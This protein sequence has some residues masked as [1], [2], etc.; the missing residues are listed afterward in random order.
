MTIKRRKFLKNSLLGALLGGTSCTAFSQP[1]SKTQIPGKFMHMVFFWLKESTDLTEFK[2]S[3]A[4][5][6]NAIPEVV[7]YHV[8]EPAGTPR[9]VVD[10]SYSVCLI[11]T[12]KS[13][14]DQD[15]YQIDPIHEA[16]VQKNN[17]KWNKVQIYDSWNGN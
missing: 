7:S 6:M 9:E 16:Y 13:K 1:K 14:E 15:K 8:G 4:A 10:N 5:L 2:S 17:D 11:A 12:F 3:T